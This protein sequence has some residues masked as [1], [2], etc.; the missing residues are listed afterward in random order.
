MTVAEDEVISRNDAYIDTGRHRSPARLLPPTG[1]SAE[2]R[3]TKA[4]QRPHQAQVLGPR[5]AS[6]SAIAD[7]VWV[8]RGGFP[9]RTMNVYLIEDDGG[10]TVFDA[11]IS[12]MTDAVRAAG[13][14]LGGIKRVV[15]GHADADHRGAAPGL[16]APVYCHAAE[17]EA[18]ESDRPLRPYWDFS[19]LGPPRRGA[20]VRTLLPAR[21]T[22]ARCTIAGTV[23]EGERSPASGSSSCPATRRA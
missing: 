9:L 21:G 18:A 12:D 13:V 16:G 4:R 22:A 14:R 6:P 1:S 15:L 19:K 2:L 17:R 5:R 20:C 3:L 23:S 10:V 7:G 11:G 8:V